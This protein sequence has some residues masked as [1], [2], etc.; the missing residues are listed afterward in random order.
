MNVPGAA[1]VAILSS[2]GHDS[3]SPLSPNAVNV[4]AIDSPSIGVPLTSIGTVIWVFP[5]LVSSSRLYWNALLVGWSTNVAVPPNE[6]TA[7]D[8]PPVPSV[9]HWR[10]EHVTAPLVP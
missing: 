7:P 9:N 4:G 1:S 6:Q 8:W 10:G 3:V 2:I 5:P